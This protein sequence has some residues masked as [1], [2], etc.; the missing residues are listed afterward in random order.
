[1]TPATPAGDSWTGPY[2]GLFTGLAII[3]S[4]LS[5]TN[6]VNA[7]N[8]DSLTGRSILGGFRA[9]Y[10]FQFESL[11][12]GLEGSVSFDD[13]R[14]KI[15]APNVFSAKA[16]RDWTVNG[17]LR[18]G[19][20]LSADTLAYALGGI[21]ASRI[22]LKTAWGGAAPGAFSGSDVYTGFHVGGGLEH[23]FMENLSVRLEYRYTGYGKKTYRIRNTAMRIDP[24]M[25]A[26]TV[27]LS[28]RF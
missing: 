15:A 9:G 22:K 23:R 20:A 24:G 8:V 28:W 2:V 25:H 11:V 4:E 26:I 1:M 19:M 27:G 7:L 17:S 13:A 5:V 6:G 14:V 3:D 21:S 18:L 12:L 16:G 10:D